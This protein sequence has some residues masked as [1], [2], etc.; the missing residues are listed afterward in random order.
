MFTFFWSL[1]RISYPI[2]TY[3]TGKRTFITLLFTVYSCDYTAN[4][5]TVIVEEK[6]PANVSNVFTTH[7]IFTL[8]AQQRTSTAYTIPHVLCASQFYSHIS[9]GKHESAWIMCC[10]SLLS[11][12]RESKRERMSQWYGRQIHISNARW[13]N[14]PCENGMRHYQ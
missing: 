1:S 3:L 11:S 10:H 6:N 2:K 13:I 7:P 9:C 14:K 4:Q 5:S 12:Q 8:N